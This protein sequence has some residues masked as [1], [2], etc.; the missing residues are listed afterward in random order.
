MKLTNTEIIAHRTSESIESAAPQIF[1]EDTELAVTNK[2][3]F[4]GYIITSDCSLEEE[5]LRRI[6]LAS[7]PFGRLTLRVVLNHSLSLARKKS[8][9]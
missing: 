7:S 4:T 1:V 8:V 6:A 2:F 9:Y 5:V 3:S